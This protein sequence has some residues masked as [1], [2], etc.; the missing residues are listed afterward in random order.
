MPKYYYQCNSSV[1][2]HW[3]EF[4]AQA[5]GNG[6][7]CAAAN[8]NKCRAHV[9]LKTKTTEKP[10]GE[11]V[12][13]Q[14][15]VNNTTLT[16]F[17]AAKPAAK[18]GGSVVPMP[19]PSSIPV[20]STSG[21]GVITTSVPSPFVPSLPAFGGGGSGISAQ[22]P[23]SRNR[24]T[25]QKSDE[26]S[27]K[28]RKMASLKD[29]EDDDSDGADDENASKRKRLDPA[30]VQ[31]QTLTTTTS[32]TSSSNVGDGS[33]QNDNNTSNNAYGSTQ[34]S[35]NIPYLPKARAQPL[36]LTGEAKSQQDLKVIF[37]A[38]SY[39]F[40]RRDGAFGPYVAPTA[41]CDAAESVEEPG[42]IKGGGYLKIKNTN[43]IIGRD[44]LFYGFQGSAHY[45]SLGT[46]AAGQLTFPDFIIEISGKTY[47]I[48]LKCVQDAFDKYI[49]T[50]FYG[51]V[52]VE[53]GGD[54][55][56]T[57]RTVEMEIRQRR[58]IDAGTPIR[59]VFDIRLCPTK[60][61]DALMIIVRHA[62][63]S[64]HKNF[65]SMINSVQFL[66]AEDRLSK[67]Y[68]VSNFGQQFSDV[69][70]GNKRPKEIEYLL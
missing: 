61:T 69:V 3:N 48:E 1:K 41:Q 9:D 10:K 16:S 2:K 15:T 25:D 40:L 13:R 24:A 4:D 46:I 43:V 12:H 7:K 68:F 51:E 23:S 64:S 53:F 37:T 5:K 27:Q 60:P 29:E 50:A 59:L 66:C 67:A 30:A 52:K 45:V 31:S 70:Q 65:W 35:P 32:S 55:E 28:K 54:G 33:L 57:S 34:A 8:T 21:T 22:D 49:N 47:S 39:R 26:N 44:E 6:I 20:G 56:Y 63:A 18:G 19:T 62:L 17:F 42:I 58:L 38:K 11:Y 14:P 36:P